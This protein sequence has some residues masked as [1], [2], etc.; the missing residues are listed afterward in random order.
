MG[1][2][3][4]WASYY[5]WKCLAI[6]DQETTLEEIGGKTYPSC[7]MGVSQEMA[8]FPGLLDLRKSEGIWAV[9][10][11]LCGVVPIGWREVVSRKGKKARAAFP[12][13]E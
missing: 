13:K 10:I 8:M 12:R 3:K 11:S 9:C 6:F 7:N 4:V 1:V 5:R 2:E